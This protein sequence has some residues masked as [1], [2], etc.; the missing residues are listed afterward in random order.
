MGFQCGIKN[1]I[2]NLIY[3][4]IIKKRYIMN[5]KEIKEKL[6]ELDLMFNNCGN[7]VEIYYMGEWGKVN[8]FRVSRNCKIGSRVNWVKCK[9]ILNKKNIKFNEGHSGWGMRMS[10]CI[11]MYFNINE[12]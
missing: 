3:L 9:N 7:G 12:E 2:I 5:D 6:N 4:I 8:S 1:I 10:R 11:D